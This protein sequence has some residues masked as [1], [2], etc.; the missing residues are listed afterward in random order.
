MFAFVTVATLFDVVIVEPVFAVYQ[1]LELS[2]FPLCTNWFSTQLDKLEVYI[3]PA[4]ISIS[5][6]MSVTSSFVS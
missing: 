5:D 4:S 1:P 2:K 6:I 3:P